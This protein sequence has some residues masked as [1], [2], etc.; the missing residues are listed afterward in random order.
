ML[1]VLLHSGHLTT[2]NPGNLMATLDI[3]YLKQ[4]AW[5]DYSVAFS[6]KGTGTVETD[7]IAK[8]PRWSGSVWDL[9][10]R[11]LTR[12][13]YRADQAPASPTPDRRCAYAT[14]LCAVVEKSTGDS[15]GVELA[16]V[17]IS[18]VG[19]QRGVYTAIFKEDIMGDR[20]ASFSYGLKSLQPAD[21]LL[22]AICWT[23][24][25]KDVLGGRPP[26]ILPP[27]IVINDV[28]LFDANALRVGGCLEN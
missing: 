11:A 9:V 16:T 24:F 22:R 14:R 5:S 26:L 12:I 27:S 8:Y 23:Y 21:L 19:N 18:Q 28:E 25:D 2:R 15:R 4:E 13:L 17:E 1:R 20:S 6:T 3:S 10:A 7:Q